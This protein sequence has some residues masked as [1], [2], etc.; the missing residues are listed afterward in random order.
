MTEL[1]LEGLNW[2]FDDPFMECA[3]LSEDDEIRQNLATDHVVSYLNQPIQLIPDDQGRVTIQ[4]GKF[5]TTYSVH[6]LSRKLDVIGAINTTM[7]KSLNESDLRLI[8][9]I[10]TSLPLDS[11]KELKEIYSFFQVPLGQNIP[12]YYLMGNHIFFEGLHF[13]APGKYTV[14]T[15]S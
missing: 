2:S 5:I 15:G 9:R 10:P 11:N 6:D 8:F 4:I 1:I 14:Y 13:D 7:Q 12:A 3:F